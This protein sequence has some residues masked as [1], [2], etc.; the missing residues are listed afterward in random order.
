[1]T[2]IE[3]RVPLDAL[4]RAWQLHTQ[5]CSRYRD[6]DSQWA[7]GL[8]EPFGTPVDMPPHRWVVSPDVREELVR[9]TSAFSDGSANTDGEDRL[10]GWPLD[11]EDVAPGTLEL[12]PQE[13]RYTRP[14]EVEE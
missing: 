10:F 11:V 6:F 5:A 1:M 3:I 8:A 13:R 14:G 9:I 4:I 2:P 7:R 12:R